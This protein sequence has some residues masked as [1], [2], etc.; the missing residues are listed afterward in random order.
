MIGTKQLECRI[1]L[2]FLRNEKVKVAMCD[3]KTGRMEKL[4]THGPARAE[5]DKV[6]KDLKT[7]IER[8][9]HLLT[10]CE[11]SE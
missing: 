9:G 4:G 7:S 5:V 10:F 2:T 8:A 1:V 3:P 11:R 6:V